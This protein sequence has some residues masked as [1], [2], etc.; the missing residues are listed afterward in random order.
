MSELR[1]RL[2]EL[3]H[4]QWSGWMEHLVRRSVVFGNGA[5][6]LQTGDL[7]IRRADAE[8]WQRQMK[9]PYSQLQSG[10]QE[11]DRKEADR[12]LALLADVAGPR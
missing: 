3:C 1:E 7:L 11:S 6:T 5:V 8:R 2:A 4:E 12:I 9:T 10:E